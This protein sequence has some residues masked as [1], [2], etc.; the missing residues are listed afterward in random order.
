MLINSP[1]KNLWKYF[2]NLFERIFENIYEKLHFLNHNIAYTV[3]LDRRQT[4][5]SQED[6]TFGYLSPGTGR[7]FAGQL[8]GRDSPHMLPTPTAAPQMLEQAKQT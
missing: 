3:A 4:K 2:K 5:D 8:R 1:S 7:H 6:K